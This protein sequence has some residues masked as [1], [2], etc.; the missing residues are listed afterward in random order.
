MDDKPEPKIPHYSGSIP[1]SDYNGSKSVIAKLGEMDIKSTRLQVATLIVA[2]LTFIATMYLYLDKKEAFNLQSQCAQR[3][4]D[5]VPNDPSAGYANAY[6]E[7]DN[8]C[9]VELTHNNPNNQV[10]GYNYTADIWDA[11]SGPSGKIY[12]QMNIYLPKGT[13]EFNYAAGKVEECF[14]GDTKCTSYDQFNSLVKTVYGIDGN[15]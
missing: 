4:K 14:V 1:L 10:G 7:K 8:R 3:A 15:F 5:F 11:N 9:Y 6:S 13:G 12:A 2:V